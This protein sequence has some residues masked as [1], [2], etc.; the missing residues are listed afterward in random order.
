MFKRE[1]WKLIIQVV[2]SILTAIATTLGV[3]SCLETNPLPTSPRGGDGASPQP[4]PP[5][6]GAE[7][8]ISYSDIKASP[9]GGELLC[10]AK[11]QSRAGRGLYSPPYGGGVGERLLGG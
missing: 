5:E 7:S 2:I 3:T 1:S 6:G 11:R 8:P 9:M 4:L 10:C